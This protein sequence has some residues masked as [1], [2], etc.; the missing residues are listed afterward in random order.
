MS[1]GLP[2][3]VEEPLDGEEFQGPA[4]ELDVAAL[5]VDYA[6]LELDLM[7]GAVPVVP[8]ALDPEALTL[9]LPAEVAPWLPSAL[10]P[11]ADPVSFAPSPDGQCVAIVLVRTAPSAFFVL[12]DASGAQWESGGRWPAAEGIDSHP[13]PDYVTAPPDGAPMIVDLSEALPPTAL[14]ISPADLDIGLGGAFFSGPWGGYRA[15]AYP[16][17][18]PDPPGPVSSGTD[19]PHSAPT[20]PVRRA[21]RQAPGPRRGQAPAPDAPPGLPPNSAVLG[22]SSK[23]SALRAALAGEF[24]ARSAAPVAGG[25]PPKGIAD[26]CALFQAHLEQANAS[27]KRC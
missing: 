5:R 10:Q 13:R 7:T 2:E 8:V 21:A 9:A 19:R 17:A 23:P 25:P 27:W 20:F 18:E 24:G 3:P 11:L 26:M 4:W 22:S 6:R 14:A 15:L 1:D 16:P 12:R